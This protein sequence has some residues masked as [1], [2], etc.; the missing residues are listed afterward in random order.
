[1]QSR[2]PLH[3]EPR[4]GG[5]AASE[6]KL[7]KTFLFTGDSGMER[8]SD[9][10]EKKKTHARAHSHPPAL[11]ID[12]SGRKSENRRLKG[13]R[14][15]KADLPRDAV[16]LRSSFTSVHVLAA[17]VPPI[18]EHQLDFVALVEGDEEDEQQQDRSQP[19]CQLH[20]VHELC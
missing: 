15:K 8:E 18:E 2:A 12:F 4:E 14:R 19:S 3:P 6:I 7:G 1:M 20:C 11:D 5:S 17:K 13:G 16:C 10:T 9:R